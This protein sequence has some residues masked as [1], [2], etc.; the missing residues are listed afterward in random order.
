MIEITRVFVIAH[1]PRIL[2]STPFIETCSATDF[3]RNRCCGVPVR[4]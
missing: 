4:I 2:R 1:N 3:C